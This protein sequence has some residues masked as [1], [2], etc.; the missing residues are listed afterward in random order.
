MRRRRRIRTPCERTVIGHE[1]RRD[2]G[3]TQLRKRPNNSMPGVFLILGCNLAIRQYFSD[4]NRRV[5]IVGVG[6][7]EAWNRLACLRPGGRILG[8]SV[9]DSANLGETPGRGQGE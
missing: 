5:E 4:G 1:D 2:R 8:M 9:G 3:I 7:A 6:R